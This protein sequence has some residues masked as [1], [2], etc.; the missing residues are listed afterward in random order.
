MSLSYYFVSQPSLLRLQFYEIS[1]VEPMHDIA[2]HADQILHE[3]PH[4]MDDG[5]VKS[6]LIQMIGIYDKSKL[7]KRCCDKRKFA[8]QVAN[9]LGYKCNG[10]ITQLLYSLAEI[11]RIMYL[12][13]SERTEKNVLRIIVSNEIRI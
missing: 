10:H 6:E 12:P 2:N 9:V 3:L 7:T 8:L 1:A 5:E 4:Q 11:Q 13:E